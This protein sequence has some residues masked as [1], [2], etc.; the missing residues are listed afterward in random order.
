MTGAVR[1]RQ[2]F[3]KSIPGDLVICHPE[4]ISRRTWI[5]GGG[6]P[7]KLRLKRVRLT[8][9]AWR[10]FGLVLPSVFEALWSG[11]MNG[12]RVVRV[13][14]WLAPGVILLQAGGCTLSALNE[15]VQTVFLGITAAG[16]IA[17]LQNI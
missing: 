11:P 12:P 9:S 7:V 1:G 10:R 4:A 15:L 17:I 14:K 2:C 3:N 8:W 5:D 13:M 6:H 16:S